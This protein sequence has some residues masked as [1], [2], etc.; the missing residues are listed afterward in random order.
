MALCTDLLA[1]FPYRFFELERRLGISP[2]PP[3]NAEEQA[4]GSKP[5][6]AIE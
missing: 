4:G 3:E 1:A 5:R 6:R 2:P